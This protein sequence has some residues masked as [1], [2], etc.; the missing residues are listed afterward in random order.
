M[1]YLLDT[2]AFLWALTEP[3]RLPDA[4]LSVVEDE[5]NELLLSAASVWEIATKL[6]LGKLPEAAAVLPGLEQHLA[7][8]GIAELAISHADAALAGTLPWDH[9]DPFDRMIAAQALRRGHV[10][11]S[12][13]DALSRCPGL[14]VVWGDPPTVR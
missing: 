2:H 3:G 14:R 7:R 6:R 10:V 9:R 4:A 1:A 13:D 12:K 8:I 11:V 5:A